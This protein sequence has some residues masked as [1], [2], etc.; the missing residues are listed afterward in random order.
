MPSFSPKLLT[1]VEANP[2]TITAYDIFVR[3]TAETPLSQTSVSSDPSGTTVV[4]I[5]SNGLFDA[6]TEGTPINIYVAETAAPGHGQ[7][8]PLALVPGGPFVVE[9]LADGAEQMIVTV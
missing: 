3:D 5:G 8:T 6:I 4:P 2:E 7:N 1:L 9:R